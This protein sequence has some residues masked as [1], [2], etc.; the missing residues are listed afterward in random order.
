MQ[1][2]IGQA[3]EAEINAWKVSHPQGIFAVTVEEHIAY[4]SNPTRL[5]VNCTLAKADAAMPLAMFEDM[6]KQLF[7][8]GSNKVLEDDEM[9]LGLVNAIKTKLDG[10]KAQLL[11]L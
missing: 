11:N 4:F 3:T 5:Q 2:Y 10:K 8:G 1:N 6:T 7:I 9:F